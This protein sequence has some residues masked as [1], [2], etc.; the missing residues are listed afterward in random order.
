MTLPTSTDRSQAVCGA[1]NQNQSFLIQRLPVTC[2]LW[3]KEAVKMNMAVASNKSPQ[4]NCK[5]CAGTQE[6]ERNT[7]AKHTG[8]EAVAVGSAV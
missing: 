3:E 7:H 1:R 2:Y 6:S 5:P 8:G 4:V